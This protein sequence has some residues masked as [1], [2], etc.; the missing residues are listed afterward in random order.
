M[1]RREVTFFTEKE[2]DVEKVIKIIENFSNYKND[3]DK[4]ISKKIQ[5]MLKLKDFSILG[6]QEI[7]FL[8]SNK[9]EIW[10]EYLIFRYKFMIY[11][12]EKTV[13]D[14]PIYVL[15]EPV[16]A[17]NLRCTMCFQ[18]DETFSGNSEYMGNMDINLFK[19][20][21]D[22]LYEGGTKAITLASRGEPTMHAKFGEMLDYCKGKFFEVKMNTNA[23]RLTDKL[24][25]K[26]LQSGVTDIVFSVDSYKKEEYE[27]IRIGGIFEQVFNNIKKF[28]DIK[29]NEYPNSKCSTRVSG[30]KVNESQNSEEFNKFWSKY[31]DHVVMVTMKHRW[32]TY[33][34]ST[35]IMSP[36]PCS[37]LWGRMYVWYDGKCNPCDEDYK[38]ELEVGN[39]NTKSIKEIWHDQQYTL[40]RKLHQEGNR[41]SV[42]PCDR[43]ANW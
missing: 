43:C 2:I 9:E 14:F 1:D 5:N 23:T 40:L 21:I 8:N 12:V 28:T 37:I 25:H 32:D 22:E 4:K 39:V 31:V 41:K 20:I 34:N 3:E 29:K 16:S 42:F 24:I 27:S 11:P 38:S 35:E 36:N 18:V 26:I 13:S 19:K 30:V 33:H 10:T 15:I 6:S 17:C 7:Q